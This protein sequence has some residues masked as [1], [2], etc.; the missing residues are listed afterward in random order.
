MKLVTITE[1]QH[2]R[3][4]KSLKL[5]LIFA[6][7][8]AIV[9]VISMNT[10]TVRLSP[11]EVFDTLL[12]NSSDKHHIILYQLRLPR[13]IIA[14]MV[15]ASLA[16]SGAILQGISRNGLADP[17][18]IG[19]NSGAGLVVLLIVV[20]K[21]TSTGVN[22]Y[23]LP[24]FALIGAALT[25]LL[26]YLLAFKKG[27]GMTPTR[28]LLVGIAVSA[29][30]SAVSIILTL[31][32]NPNEYD[33]VLQ[34]NLGNLYG[35]NWS[36]VLALLPWTL[37]LLPYVYYKSHVLN[38]LNLNDALGTSL[39]LSL[40]REKLYLLAVA[41]GLAA[42]AVAIGGGIGF[43]GLMGPHIARKLV[44]PKHQFMLPVTALI[45]SLLVLTGDTIARSIMKYSE[46]PAGIIITLIGAPYFL[47]LLIKS[48]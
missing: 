19:I 39:G 26:I 31:R 47:Y 24:L 40:E 5:I 10:G 21:P 32:L 20:M 29:G 46:L 42:S 2:K 30:L 34:W 38:L 12:G 8:L 36:F 27:E 33:F 23:I 35:G 22:P 45:G 7:L 1:I 25:A 13:M 9:F 48:K 11:Q 41:V 37:L 44:G 43:I 28:L 17:G 6:I 18:I 15:G 14:I 3:M 4:V 16:I